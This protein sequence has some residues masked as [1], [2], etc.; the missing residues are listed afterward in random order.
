M[1]VCSSCGSTYADSH[2]QCPECAPSPAA[3]EVFRCSECEQEYEGEVGCPACGALRTEVA[4]AV[5][6]ERAA[7]GQC[8]ICGKPGCEE[9][10]SGQG[11]AHL[12]PEH[13][14]IPIIEGWAQVYSETNEFE[15]Q[16][17]R[18]NLRAEGIDAQI[19]SQRDRA[20]SLDLGELSI[21][22]LLVPV[23]EYSQA[24]QIVRQH[25]D[26]EGEV[27]FACPSC[28]EAYEPGSRECTACGASLV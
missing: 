21:V 17:L 12:C 23:W 9:C 27:V 19:F 22:R 8:V 6:P 18:E 14:S 26:R 5:H 2:D 3:A 4:C 25:M 15:A 10:D 11:P 20:F 13:R 16:L 1:A 24:L 28:G 7:V